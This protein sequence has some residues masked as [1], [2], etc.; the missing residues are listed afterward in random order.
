M[1]KS[2]ELSVVKCENCSFVGLDLATWHYPYREKDYY[3]KINDCDINPNRPFISNRVNFVKKY[4]GGRRLVELGCGLGET[5]IALSQSGFEVYGV[6]ESSNAID[7]LKSHYQGIDWICSGVSKF[8][9]TD[10][11][12]DVLTLFHVLE[13]IPHPLRFAELCRNR[14]NRG[15]ILVVEV[16]DV[17]GG[18]AKIKGAK[19]EHWLPHHVNY[20]SIQSLCRLFEPFGL[21]LVHRQKLYH[22]GWPQ[23]ILWRDLIHNTLAIMGINSIVRTCFRLNSETK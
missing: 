7:F 15:G 5:A 2:T 21:H 23:G 6:E 16:P 1:F 14:L 4:A 20:F 17:C 19:W 9:A 8:L 11:R 3:T 22:F 18:I 10:N 13:H 12:F